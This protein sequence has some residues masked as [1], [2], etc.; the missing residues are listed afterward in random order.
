MQTVL[1]AIKQTLFNNL[2]RSIARYG[3]DPNRENWLMEKQ[4]KTGRPLDPAQIILLVV[5]IYY[6][7]Q[8]EEAF[9][10]LPTNPRAMKDQHEKTLGDQI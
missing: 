5:A 7:Q 8:V 9:A 6:V 3:N 4:K 2:K 1:D 10:S